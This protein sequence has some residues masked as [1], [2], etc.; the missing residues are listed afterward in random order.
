MRAFHLSQVQE[1]PQS[2]FEHIFTA[3]QEL[4]NAS[5]EGTRL[6]AGK[7]A[8]FTAIQLAIFALLLYIWSVLGDQQRCVGGPLL[9]RMDLITH[10]RLNQRNSSRFIIWR[11]SPSLLALSE[12]RADP[13][14]SRSCLRGSHRLWSVPSDDNST[15]TGPA[16]R[17]T[18]KRC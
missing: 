9:T 10:A 7:I 18:E 15:C 8:A 5:T 14:N 13:L 4:H 12:R 3:N 2:E 6:A 16:M 17:C 1:M 11:P